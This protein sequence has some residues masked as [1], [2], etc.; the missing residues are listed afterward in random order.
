MMYKQK[1]IIAGKLRQLEKMRAYLAYSTHRMREQAIAGKN[2]RRLEEADAE[3]LT[4][5]RIGKPRGTSEMPSITTMKKMH[6]SW[7][8]WWAKC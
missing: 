5:S 8:C 7:P 1:D 3:I 4:A 6:K 2:L